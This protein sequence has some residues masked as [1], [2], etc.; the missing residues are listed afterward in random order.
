MIAA[1]HEPL[2]LRT[3]AIHA[4]LLALVLL[5]V[6]LLCVRHRWI[7]RSLSLFS[8]AAACTPITFTTT[9]R[10]ALASASTAITDGTTTSLSP[11]YSEMNSPVAFSSIAV[12]Q[13]ERSRSSSYASSDARALPK[14]LHP[15][16]MR[17]RELPPASA[18]NPLPVLVHVK[19]ERVLLIA[20][21]CSSAIAALVF[22]VSRGIVVARF[23]T[24]PQ[25][26]ARH[27]R[28]VDDYNFYVGAVT[29]LAVKPLL[30]LVAA[31][32]PMA[33]LCFAT[34]SY[35][36]K[37]RSWPAHV[38]IFVVTNAIV[39]LLSNGFHAANVQL[40]APR[41]QSVLRSNDLAA[42][43]A[44]SSTSAVASSTLSRTSARLTDVR[45][46]IL[47]SALAQ[48]TVTAPMTCERES[49][50]RLPAVVDFGFPAHAWLQDVLPTTVAPV[51]TLA[52][53]VED[54]T[55]SAASER[56]ARLPIAPS[57]AQ[58]LFTTALSLMDDFFR[59]P[60]VASTNSSKA[61]ELDFP[62]DVDSSSDATS[63]A[64][65]TALLHAMHSTLRTVFKA[66]SPLAHFS[67][68]E[69]E[70][71]T[72]EFAR[73]ELS[74]QITFDAV[75]FDIPLA[76][77]ALARRVVLENGS[78]TTREVRY[79]AQ[80]SVFEIN[81][82][83]ECSALGCVVS[84]DGAPLT[85]ARVDFGSQVR[86]LAICL[87]NA[88]NTEDWR[89]TLRGACTATSKSS[90]LVFSFA[91]R[92]AGGALEVAR[93]S[94]A[95]LV[96]LTNATKFYTVT[97]GRLAWRVTDIAE[98]FHA[99][100]EA[101]EGCEGLALPLQQHQQRQD[102]P[103]S[104]STGRHVVVGKAQLPQAQVYSRE[105]RQLWGTQL[106]GANVQ[107]ID[108]G[109]ALKSDFVFPRNFER[110]D[111]WDGAIQG[112]ACEVERER[113]LTRVVRDHLFSEDSRQPAYSAALFWL[114]QRAV[115]HD[116]QLLSAEG[117][118]TTT[119]LAFSGNVA[120]VDAE[121]S[122]PRYSAILTCAG[123]GVLLVLALAVQ[124]G[125]KRREAHIERFFRPH[126]LAQLV[127]GDN[128]LPQHLIKCDLLHVANDR[129]GS[130]EHLDE[131]EIS[132]LALRHCKDPG[133]VLYV[134]K[135]LS[136]ASSSFSSAT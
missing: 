16:H 97:V 110:V 88:T 100:C 109:G 116:A 36:Q 6:L 51:G 91:K 99:T 11:R 124:L 70:R 73:Y 41:I 118:T 81:A 38:A 92:I 48:S 49:P 34:Q 89:A 30:A 12:S 31:V 84:P 113:F 24:T 72:V 94:S 108:G 82:K 57:V 22:V 7:K 87:D 44:D 4:L 59:D 76:A 60:A 101:D 23:E 29:S 14:Y 9:T 21:V 136:T 61:L 58:D 63:A 71:A 1:P 123:C 8:T 128:Q 47:R 117:A 53:S 125:G 65:E 119:T 74:P 62:S 102:S 103:A 93:N 83:E 18:S 127:L 42:A 17:E 135:Q 37:Q 28:S 56:R 95:T 129:L 3:R 13:S 77:S 67:T 134:P 66:S 79:A 54:M 39:W 35:M 126:Q 20:L 106:V 90:A 112:P 107:E 115:V 131:F 40:R 132:G 86:A 26:T 105:S 78:D 98:A 121:L 96:T 80:D 10:Y 43:A 75:T 32:V 133:N 104:A 111:G 2:T 46:S 50:R 55:A 130:S 122:V 45:D 120:V 19:K 52:L 27:R 33:L 69:A 25:D 15:Q 85:T 5:V 64:S 114:L 68:F